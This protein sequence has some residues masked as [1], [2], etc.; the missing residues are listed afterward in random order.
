MA[1]S[2]SVSTDPEALAEALREFGEFEL[3]ARIVTL[4]V[5]ELQSIWT[6]GGSIAS[7]GTVA[8]SQL[9]LRKALVVAAVEVLE[10]H[11]RP[12]NDETAVSH[13]VLGTGLNR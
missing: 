3:A 11:A 10:G 8:Y 9:P 5:E 6:R 12:L 2:V 4:S 1:T 13:N 7:G